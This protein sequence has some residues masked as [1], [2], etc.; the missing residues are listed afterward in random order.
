MTYAEYQAYMAK[1]G[2]I[3]CPLT[4]DQFE[5]AV[6]LGAEVYG[7]GCDVNAGVDFR[8]AC[9]INIRPPAEALANP[10]RLYIVGKSKGGEVMCKR[11]TWIA[12][13]GYASD[14]PLWEFPVETIGL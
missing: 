5:A 9:K 6:K 3:N 11:Y 8:V 14:F 4:A 13:P 1:Y 7:V 2:F 10:L 12:E